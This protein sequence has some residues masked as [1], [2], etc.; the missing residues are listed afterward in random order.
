M[1]PDDGFITGCQ[2][3]HKDHQP[4]ALHNFDID[5]HLREGVHL[6]EGANLPELPEGVEQT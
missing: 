4:L 1:D 6:P 3:R 5:V 2:G